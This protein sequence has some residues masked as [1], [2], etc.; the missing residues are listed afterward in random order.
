MT[1]DILEQP[2][3]ASRETDVYESEDEL[4]DALRKQADEFKSSLESEPDNTEPEVQDEAESDS[5]E[6][7]DTENTEEQK[8]DGD[9]DIASWLKKNPIK[10]KDR[11]LTIEVDDLEEANKLINLGLNYTRKTQELSEVRKVADYAKQHSID[12]SDLELLADLKTGRKEALAELAKRNSVDVYDIDT[13]AS[14]QPNNEVVY[15]EASE[16]DM[17]AQEIAQDEVLYGKVKDALTYVPRNFAESVVSDA[18]L[19]SAFRDDVANGIADKVLPVAIKNHAV[20]GGDF[21]QHYVAVANQMFSASQEQVEPQAPVQ[22]AVSPQT[23][24]KASV[25]SNASGI[26]NQELDLWDNVGESELIERI[27]RQ[28]SLMRG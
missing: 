5:A 8:P 18:K 1:E 26:N 14:Y 4:L 22:Q 12:I 17:V 11:D 21:I 19:L 20:R 23:K 24:A 3:T 15:R 2:N 7:N 27:K 6:S 16:V 9:F 10:A 25:G 28:A 13:D